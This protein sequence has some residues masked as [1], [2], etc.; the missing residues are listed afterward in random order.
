M[1]SRPSGRPLAHSTGQLTAGAV[2]SGFQVPKAR[3]GRCFRGQ[4][5]RKLKAPKPRARAGDP[6]E[7]I[8]YRYTKTPAQGFGGVRVQEC[9]LPYGSKT[10]PLP[11]FGHLGARR[12]CSSPHLCPRGARMDCLS[13][14]AAPP[15]CSKGLLEPPLGAPGASKGLLETPL[16]APRALQ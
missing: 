16:S 12:G 1:L 10:P 8:S 5:A 14:S 13:P 7:N 6:H 9:L 4:V 3:Q 11:C 15:E 2:V